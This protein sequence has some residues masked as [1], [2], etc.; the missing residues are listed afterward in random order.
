MYICSHVYMHVL[1]CFNAV[2]VKCWAFQP[3]L[4]GGRG[5][6]KII[7]HTKW[8][9]TTHSKTTRNTD[10]TSSGTDTKKNPTK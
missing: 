3:S 2:Y 1:I 6:R 4:R 7:T 9:H 8:T 10:K 5:S